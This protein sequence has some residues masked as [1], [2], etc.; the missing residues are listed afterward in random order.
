VENGRIELPH[1]R[2]P[3]VKFLAIFSRGEHPASAFFVTVINE[4]F[5]FSSFTIA[6]EEVGGSN[7]PYDYDGGERD[8]AP[9]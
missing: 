2:A 7:S 5:A 1:F 8:D 6:I 9:S 3:V 4:G